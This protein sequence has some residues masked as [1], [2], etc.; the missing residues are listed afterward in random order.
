MMYLKAYAGAVVAFLILDAIWLGLIARSY[1][2]EQ[3]GHLMSDSPNWLAAGGFYLI[4]I[5]GIVILAIAP[6]VEAGSWSKAL[7]HGAVL[8]LV[9]YGT[10]DMTNL[11]VLRDWPIAMTVIDIAWGTG[12]TAVASVA[13][14]SVALR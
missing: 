4:Y 6:A 2:R 1:Y 14:Y 13:G 7:I 3:I 11:A 10:Y 9:A 5:A 12:L 8:G